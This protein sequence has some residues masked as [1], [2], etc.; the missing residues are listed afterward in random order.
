MINIVLAGFVV[1]CAA[2]CYEVKQIENKHNDLVRRTCEHERRLNYT[3]HD[4]QNLNEV[5]KLLDN[6]IMS[7]NN[8]LVERY[9]GKEEE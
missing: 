5:N 2:V 3:A 4:I 9:K 7:V 1:A 6:N 8:T